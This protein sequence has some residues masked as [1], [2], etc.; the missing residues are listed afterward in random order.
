MVAFNETPNRRIP[1]TS[2]EVDPSGA[3]GESAAKLRY[4]ALL[5]AYKLPAGTAAVDQVYPVTSAAQVAQLAGEHSQAHHHAQAWFDF[6]KTTEAFVG[7][8]DAPNAGTAQT[9]TVTLTG[10]ASAAGELSLYIGGRAARVPVADTDTATDIGTALAAAINAGDFP[11]TA[12]ALTGVVTLT[13][14]HKGAFGADLDVRA[15]Y[16]DGEAFPAGVGATIVKAVAGTGGPDFAALFAAIEDER[17]HIVTHGF[18]DAPSMTAIEAEMERR[19]GP[20]VQIGGQAI[21]AKDGAF[22]PVAAYGESRNTPHHTCFAVDASPRPAGEV[23]AACA[24][25]VAYYGEIDPAR[26]FQTL[27]VRWVLPARKADRFTAGERDLLL[28]SGISTTKVGPGDVTQLER[29]ITMYRKSPAGADDESYLDLTTRLTLLYAINDFLTAIPLRYPR[30]KCGDDGVAYPPGEP[31][32]TPSTMK[33]ELLAWYDRMSLQTPIVFD[34]AKRELFKAGVV[35]ERNGS[36]RFDVFAPPGLIGQ[37]L[38]TAMKLAFRL[39]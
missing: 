13:A 2:V 22:G 11:V 33:A 32:V 7:L 20:T 37:L 26:P 10:P 35:V 6:N 27:P 18:T 29:V 1:F 39:N 9:H 15:N 5:L 30:A 25:V 19:F 24:S 14:R 16:Q 23:A 36:T 28:Y 8:L 4:R 3:M 17:F 34:P 21:T 12:V 31:V 38:Q